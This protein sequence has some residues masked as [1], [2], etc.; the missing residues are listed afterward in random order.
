MDLDIQFGELEETKPRAHRRP[1]RN[2]HYAA[3]KVGAPANRD[4]PIFVDMDVV[5]DMEA[6]ARSDTSVELGGVLLGGQYEDDDGRPFVVV[7]DSL[8]AQHYEATK[9]SF[10]FTHDTWTQ[11]TRQRD[12]FPEELQM[13]GWYHTHPDW[14]VFLSG[15]D[16]F[17]CDNF[18][19]KPLDVA[20]VIDP[21][22]DDRGWFQWTGDP[23]H[24][25]RRTGGYY[26]IASRFR[27]PELELL[28]AHLEGK[29]TMA[30]DPRFSGQPGQLPPYPA[31]VVNIASPRDQWQSIAVMGM[32]TMQFLLVALIAY[33]MMFPPAGETG[34]V[35]QSSL[36]EQRLVEAER[37]AAKSEAVSQMA[38]RVLSSLKDAQPGSFPSLVEQEQQVE[39]LRATVRGQLALERELKK[40]H[41]ELLAKH[42]K[43]VAEAKQKESRL[44]SDLQDLKDANRTL[45]T[46]LAKLSS[47]LEA[48]MPA[49][50]ED[51]DATA[52]AGRSWTW[53]YI[54][55]AVAA[56]VLVVAGIGVTFVMRNRGKENGE[57]VSSDEQ[58]K[59]TNDG[60]E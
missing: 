9:G 24:R 41:D 51:A 1:D 3:V 37:A 45:E 22:R 52:A 55:G 2:K 11:I 59:R 5:R 13:V 30:H 28:A 60:E 12:E 53:L 44:N 43:T 14:G 58:T 57:K 31:P 20:L 39:E 23:K 17:I 46:K 15:M 26:L 25:V 16:M 49:P 42:T 33:R 29:L 18:F 6:H 19:N 35:A 34:A 40:E 50:A 10:K 36:L 4:L 54:S 48:L 21:C 38:D 8:R 56:A 32:L 27:Q 47:E 7:T